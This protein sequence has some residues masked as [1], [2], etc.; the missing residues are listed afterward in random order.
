MYPTGVLMVTFLMRRPVV[1]GALLGLGWAS[2][3]R[4]WMRYISTDPDFSWSGTI[5]ILVAGTIVG[6]VLGFARKRRRAGGVGWWRLSIL[7]LMLLGA[8]GAVMW[9]SVVLGAAAIGRL[10]PRWLRLGLG[11]ATVAAQIPVVNAAVLNAT[12]STV[13]AVVAVVWYAPMLAIEAW[14]FSVVF[15]PSVDGAPVPGKVKK[16]LIAVPVAGM[17]AFAAVTMGIPG[18]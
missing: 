17:A 18:M 14:A 10:R 4:T 11:L 6:S 15:A 8:G 3:M 9:P 5:F 16:A 1:A 12:M 13:E 2:V 7:S